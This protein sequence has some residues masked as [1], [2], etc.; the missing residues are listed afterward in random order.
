[1]NK[2]YILVGFTLNFSLLFAQECNKNVYS[3]DEAIKLSTYGKNL[4]KSILEKNPADTALIAKLQ[5]DYSTDLCGYTDESVIKISN[6]LKEL[7]KLD[8]INKI[9]KEDIKPI[10]VAKIEEEPV[11]PKEAAPVTPSLVPEVKAVETLLFAPNSAQIKPSKF[12]VLVTQLKSDKNATVTIDGYADADA[13]DEYNLK[14][15]QK[16]ANSVKAYLISKGINSSRIT[17]NAYG[18]K[19]PIADN[20]TPEGKAK[21]RRVVI[22]V[23]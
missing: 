16:R 14:L 7:E 5:G 19:N 15:S 6:Y 23:K 3:E 20:E 1:M 13:S 4:E 21:N 9:V 12:A 11:R 2:L 10:E 22:S 8:S 17:I 18:E